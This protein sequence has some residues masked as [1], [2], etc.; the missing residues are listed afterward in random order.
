[1][2]IGILTILFFIT[3]LFLKAQP[4]SSQQQTVNAAVTKLFDGIAEL[5]FAKMKTS[6]TKD[7][8]ILESGAI[9][10]MDSLTSRL[11]PLKKMS[12][13]RINN[14]NF[15]KTEIKGNAAWVYYNNVAD[16][17][18]NGKQRNANW[19]ES[20]VLVKEGKDWKVK[21]LHSTTIQQK[22]K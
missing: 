1:M 21:L 13:K 3:S 15:I 14:L 16:M 17:I 18:I 4:F 5:D 9:W 20:A 22:T 19:L 7:V 8:I 11:E 10:T 12:Y 6:A 2:R